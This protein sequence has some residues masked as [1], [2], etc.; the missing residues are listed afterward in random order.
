MGTDIL[1]P[2]L[3]KPE[4]SGWKNLVGLPGCSSR[5]GE[6]G[7]GNS[8]LVPPTHLDLSEKTQQ[9]SA[10]GAAVPIKHLCVASN[11]GPYKAGQAIVACG[12]SSGK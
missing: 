8:S 1:K 3:P 2:V 9:P 12:S 11:R 5:P 6:A 10:L 7:Q 4:P